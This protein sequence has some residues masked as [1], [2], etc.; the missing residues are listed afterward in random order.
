MCYNVIRTLRNDPGKGV[1]E[2]K[3]FSLWEGYRE[4]ARWL[5]TNYWWYADRAATRE[6]TRMAEGKAVPTTG[7]T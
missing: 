6:A 2:M 1:K 3:P 7:P 5:A 4:I